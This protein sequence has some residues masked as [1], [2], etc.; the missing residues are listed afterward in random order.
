M[1]HIGLKNRPNIPPPKK[2]ITENFVLKP[3]K[4]FGKRKKCGFSGCS[5]EK[6]G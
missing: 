3:D 5:C 2:L 4:F 6:F 1:K